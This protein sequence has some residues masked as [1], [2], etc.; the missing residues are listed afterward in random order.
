MPKWAGRWKGGRYYLDEEGRPVF[1]IE[2]RVAGRPKSLKLATHDEDLAKGELAQFEADPLGYVR[3]REAAAEPPPSGPEPVYI[4]SDRINLYLASKSLRRACDD[5]RSAR[6]SYLLAWS[7]KKLDLRTVDE[8]TL[9]VKLAEFKGGHNGRTEALNAFARFLVKKRVLPHW[10]PLDCEHEA[11]R[12]RAPRVAYDLAELQQKYAAID[13]Q[14]VRDVFRI[15]VATGMHH[16]EIEQFAGAKLY[17]GPLPDLGVG[18][19]KLGEGH[20]I[21]GVLQFRQK[22]KP[23]HRVSVTLDVLEAALRLR[24]KGVPDRE[25]LW[26]K[27]KPLTP[28]NLRHTYITLAGEV[29]EWVTYTSKGVPLDQIQQVVGHRLGSK[30]T[31]SHYDKLQVPPMIRLPL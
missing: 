6:S 12:T 23:R 20:L 8:D 5:H 3:R 28:S 31:Q 27:L 1:F 15:R 2:R 22:T 16:T 19:R 4:T 21:R 11:K 10:T 17:T 26:E 13:R 29:G 24:E 14:D 9:R 25:V 30:V 18:I 7:E